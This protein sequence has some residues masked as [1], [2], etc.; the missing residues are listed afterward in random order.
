MIDKS[1][2]PDH[3]YFIDSIDED[4]KQLRLTM[5][6]DGESSMNSA[7]MTVI[8]GSV[9]QVVSDILTEGSDEFLY[10]V[11]FIGGY[12]G[13]MEP[14]EVN[15]FG[16]GSCEAT[17]MHIINGMNRNIAAKTIDDGGKKSSVIVLDK[18]YF[19]DE[20]GPIFIFSVPPIFT[21]FKNPQRVERI[22]VKDIDTANVWENGRSSFRLQY[23]IDTTPC[24]AYNSLATDIQH[25]MS[26]LGGLCNGLDDCVTVTKSSDPLLA[27]NGF[28]YSIFFTADI[29]PVGLEIQDSDMSCIPFSDVGGESIILESIMYSELSGAFSSQFIALGSLQSSTTRAKWLRPDS[30]HLS[31]YQITGKRWSIEFENYLGDAPSFHALK[32]TLPESSST[33]KIYDN[34]VTGS[35]PTTTTIYE[36]QTGIPYHIRM[37]SQNSVGMSKPSNVILGVASD[38]PGVLM[39]FSIDHVTHVEEIQS[40]S[41]GATRIKE[42]QAI[43]TEASSIPEVQEVSIISENNNSVDDGYFSLRNPEIQVIRWYSGSEVTQGSY[44]LTLVLPDIETSTIDGIGVITT[45]MLKTPCISFDATANE[46]KSALEESA[47]ENGLP[48]NSIEVQRSGSGTRSSD[49]GYIYTIRF[50]GGSVR[51]NVNE[52]SSDLSLEGIDSSGGNSCTPFN[53]PTD[54]ELLS[55][56]TVSAENTVGTD[57]PRAALIVSA[58]EVIV[59]GE[60][61]LSIN[62]MGIPQTTECIPWN[63]DGFFVETALEALSNVDSVFVSRTGSGAL[64]DASEVIQSATFDCKDGAISIMYHIEDLPI[65]F[66]V[67]DRIQFNNQ[68]DKSKYYTITSIDTHSQIITLSQ[69][70][71]GYDGICQATKFFSYRYDIYFDGQ[72][73]HPSTSSNGFDPTNLSALTLTSLRQCK[74]FKTRIH[75][76]VKEFSELPHTNANI[77]ITS[78]YSGGHKLPAFRTENSA[79]L[80][81]QAVASSFKPFIFTP[82]ISKSLEDKDLGVTYT[83]RFDDRDGDTFQLVCNTDEVLELSSISCFTTTVSDGNEVSGV[84]YINTS[85]AVPFDASAQELKDVL[86]RLPYI[87][88]VSVSRSKADGQAGFTWF[89]TF[90]KYAGDVDELFLTSGLLGNNATI[91]V[92]E[93]TK[94]NE[95][96][97]H[98]QLHY[99]NQTTD[100]IS[101][102]DDALA[103]QSAL[104][105]L[106]GLEFVDVDQSGT[107]T[108]EG[109]KT[110]LVTFRSSELGDLELLTANYSSLSGIGVTITTREE[111]KGSLAN[112]NALRISYDYPLS[113]SQSNVDQ[114]VCGSP[115]SDVRFEFDTTGSFTGHSTT[116]FYT[117]DDAVQIVRTASSSFASNTYQTP[118]IS[119]YFQLSHLDYETT[120]I[121]ATSSS[122]E[123]RLALESLPFIETVHVSRDLSKEIFMN[124]CVD[125]TAGSS[126]VICSPGCSCDF[127]AKGLSPNDMIF[128]GSFWYRIASFY[129]GSEDHFD[130]ALVENSLVPIGYIERTASN[131]SL[132]RWAGGYEWKI[133]FQKVLTK[134]EHISS[135]IHHLL[136][137]DS[138][139]EINYPRCDKCLHI[140]KLTMWR[141]YFVRATV[142]NSNGIGPFTPVLSNIPKGKAQY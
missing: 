71:D 82:Y 116:I 34:I 79:Q 6:F 87:G 94:G 84:F 7:T 31:L 85:D 126:Q 102:S 67:G 35:N 104:R 97:G 107:L 77:L 44:F 20:V 33:V 114:G 64:G 15:V 109:G 113:C 56:I 63:S 128:I 90:E 98:F 131:Q 135:P 50:T 13:N 75:G 8:I 139:V 32:N 29:N 48:P 100:F 91:S 130:L 88:E 9:P 21:V 57:T 28:V 54:D 78:R 24:I 52:F 39:D 124:E 62:Y 36:L 133:T 16:D 19:G 127:A 72:A 58:D 115:I 60:F 69:P 59:E 96:R 61:E 141:S 93:I 17:S 4:G 30:F 138:I 45:K 43:R 53:A 117:P 111:R 120:P 26:N 134:L 3:I 122:E 112:G 121:G 41:V 18:G 73:M 125:V 14:P 70:Y 37:K 142:V 47:L 11:Y 99:G 101:Q 10:D 51:G 136:P 49:F 106:K 105:S 123:M 108:S 46:F 86:E 65:N 89:I 80:I 83:V 129:S 55:I 119:G 132:Y 95:I 92:K 81:S 76:A 27:P 66:I 118:S 22:I 38:R 12:W 137:S 40:I 74:S 140:D 103:V 42:I 110:F 2:Y 5:P 1:Y 68:Q 25:H 23:G